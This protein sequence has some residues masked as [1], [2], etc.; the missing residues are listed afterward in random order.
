MI[1]SFVCEAV[2]FLSDQEVKVLEAKSTRKGQPPKPVATI[3]EAVI[4]IARLGGYLA[5]KSDPP[6]GSITLWRGWKRLVDLTE[7]WELA[8]AINT[9]G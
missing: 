6:P 3:A 8:T 7:G 9:Y 1:G 5:R 4:M 2:R